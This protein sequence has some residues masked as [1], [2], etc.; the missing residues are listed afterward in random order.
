M[1]LYG[2]PPPPSDPRI[3]RHLHGR[4]HALLRQIRQ[5]LRHVE[6]AF[7]GRRTGADVASWLGAP[8]ASY[9]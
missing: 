2:F 4:F 9:K 7:G 8:E 1:G 6:G 3:F 5:L